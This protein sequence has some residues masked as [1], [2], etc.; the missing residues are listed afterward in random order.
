MFTTEHFRRPSLHETISLLC[1]LS[2]DCLYPQSGLMMP[3]WGLLWTKMAQK[4]TYKNDKPTKVKA[5]SLAPKTADVSMRFSYTDL[6]TA[7]VKSTIFRSIIALS[8]QRFN[9]SFPIVAEEA[10]V[11]LL[12]TISISTIKCK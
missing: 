10:P 3:A 6:C 1:F 12:S 7:K 9:S 11:S 4:T 2:K 5:N 8:I